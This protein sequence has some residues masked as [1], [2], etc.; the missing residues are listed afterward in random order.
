MIKTETKPQKKKIDFTEGPIFW[1]LILF[2]LPIMA[3]GLL[4]MLYN[5]ADKWVVGQFSG[6]D[7]ALGAIGC[8]ATLGAFIINF[9]GDLL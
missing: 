9:M 4:Q 6:D 8:T 3:T 2:A 7:L 1:R 5:A